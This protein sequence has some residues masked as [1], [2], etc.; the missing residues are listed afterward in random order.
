MPTLPTTSA[1]ALSLSTANVAT[2]YGNT[3]SHVTVTGT[4]APPIVAISRPGGSITVTQIV[5]VPGGF[6]ISGRFSF[7]AQRTDFYTD[8]LGLLPIR[9]TFVAPLTTRTLC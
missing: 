2:L 4:F 3:I 9:G 7:L 6:A 8:P 1:P 5:P